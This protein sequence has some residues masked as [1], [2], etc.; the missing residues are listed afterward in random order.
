[1]PKL[2]RTLVVYYTFL[3]IFSLNSSAKEFEIEPLPKGVAP[4]LK[5]Y[6]KGVASKVPSLLGV[7]LKTK[8]DETKEEIDKIS[9]KSLKKTKTFAATQSRQPIPFSEK[10][11]LIGDSN[12]EVVM[13]HYLDLNCVKCRKNQT[14]IY[15]IYKRHKKDGQSIALIHK[16]K[17]E[18]PFS[19]NNIAS[20]YGRIAQ[21]HGLYWPYFEKIIAGAPLTEESLRDIL[22]DL[23]IS[24]SVFQY[25]LRKLARKLYMQLDTEQYEAERLNM[26]V[27]PAIFVNGVLIGGGIAFN[28]IEDFIDFEYRLAIRQK[29]QKKGL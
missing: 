29:V 26:Q 8:S 7:T 14:K 23:G 20:F 22:I 18:D 28:D 3:T 25:N 24:E 5:V 1:M 4:N 15:D 10:T 17:A 16:Y 6:E 9:A 11:P 12:A 19:S 13:V 2:V 21:E 27:K